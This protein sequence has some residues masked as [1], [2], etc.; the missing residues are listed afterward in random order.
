MPGSTH[1]N[2]VSAGQLISGGTGNP[3]TDAL[4]KPLWREFPGVLLKIQIP[5]PSLDWLTRSLWGQRVGVRWEPGVGG[6][7]WEEP[8]WEGRGRRSPTE[9]PPTLT[10]QPRIPVPGI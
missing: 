7:R 9:A 4:P 1:F 2:G 6:A 5:G 3:S 10:A 8:G